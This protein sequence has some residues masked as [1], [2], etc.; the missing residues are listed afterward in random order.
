MI[1]SA[2]V[3]THLDYLDLTTLTVSG[4]ASIVSDMVSSHAAMLTELIGERVR[5]VETSLRAQGRTLIDL[6]PLDALADRMISV[7][8]ATI[9]AERH[10]GPVY[11]PGQV[12]RFMDISKQA[13][14]ER[15][16]R[17][18]LLGVRT[19]EGTWV[20]PA[21]QFLRRQPL[22]GLREVLAAFGRETTTDLTVAAWLNS[23]KP[24]LGGKT[25]YEWLAKGKA[26]DTVVELA[27]RAAH[28]LSA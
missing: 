23:P 10:V 8:P 1:P 15:T 28:R 20:Y 13:L 4:R 5:G 27:G 26:L 12:C 11:R 22:S 21:A 2:A 3:W 6:G 19:V 14:H 25:V 18:S 9:L 16:V 7:L 24:I 17:R